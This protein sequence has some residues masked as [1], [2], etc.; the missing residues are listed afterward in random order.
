MRPRLRRALQRPP[1]GRV[2]RARGQPG[3]RPGL[4]PRPVRPCPA[5]RRRT[6]WPRDKLVRT[7]SLQV[8]VDD[9]EAGAA[10][11]R[12]IAVAAGG[13]VVSENS[14]AVPSGG[15]KG[16]VDKEG[17]RSVLALA[18][19]SDSLD[20]VLDDVGKLGTTVQRSSS[21]R[22]VTSTYVDTQSRIATM[23]ASLDQLRALLAKT[24]SIDQV[25]SLETEASRRQ[26]DLDSLQAQLN[27][28]DKKVSMSTLT[29]NLATAAQVVAQERLPRWAAVRVGGVPH[30]VRGRADGAR[31][32]VAVPR[33]RRAGRRPD[34]RLVAAP[35]GGGAPSGRGDARW[36]GRAPQ[37]RRPRWA[38]RTREF[39][40]DGGIRRF[41][42]FR[43]SRWLRG[44]RR[45]G[46]L[47]RSGGSGGSGGS[48]RYRAGARHRGD[49]GTRARAGGRSLRPACRA[50]ARRRVHG[51]HGGNGWGTT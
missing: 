3:R 36:L 50:T 21:S 1:T 5:R 2:R 17:S 33:P 12:R 11:V 42:R 25:V 49:H 34:L 45:L 15:A 8:Q 27:A 41:R 28:L 47:G 13:M 51:G 26:A 14:S 23:K 30:D 29:V 43:R 22:D 39:R 38:V 7:A 10:D 19:P 32:A 31:R 40:W 4:R 20:R 37:R 44:V 6:S 9:V 18:V 35:P 24:T 16:S 48:E 46:R